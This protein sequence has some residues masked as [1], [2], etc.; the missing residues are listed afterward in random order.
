VQSLRN[1]PQTQR[2]TVVVFSRHEAMKWENPSSVD[3]TSV[4]RAQ[5]KRSYKNCI[6]DTIKTSFLNSSLNSLIQ[7]AAVF[8]DR[9]GNTND[10]VNLTT[11][12]LDREA[13]IALLDKVLS[14][15]SIKPS[16]SGSIE[17]YRTSQLFKESQ[18]SLSMI[19]SKTD[20]KKLKKKWQIL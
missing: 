9:N 15:P 18:F 6:A 12:S 20:R 8:R 19:D 4:R 13:A 1:T 17:K 3:S 10:L 11:S 14:R 5:D 7:T 16:R 2:K